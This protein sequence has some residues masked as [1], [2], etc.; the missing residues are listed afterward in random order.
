MIY[1][2]LSSCCNRM[3]VRDKMRRAHMETSTA[4]RSKRK[5]KDKLQITRSQTCHSDIMSSFQQ[6]SIQSPHDYSAS[7]SSIV[8]GHAQSSAIAI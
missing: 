5:F 7:C 3:L 1:T 6:A 2:L 4:E 8:H